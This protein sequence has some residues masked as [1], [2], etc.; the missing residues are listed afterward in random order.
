MVGAG[1]WGGYM[2]SGHG[3]NG[4]DR[5][6]RHAVANSLLIIDAG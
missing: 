3:F 4:R 1:V 5:V 6:G 2:G